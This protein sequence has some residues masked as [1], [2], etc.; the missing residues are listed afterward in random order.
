MLGFAVSTLAEV[1]KPC[2]AFKAFEV[3]DALMK[4]VHAIL[5]IRQPGQNG[6]AAEKF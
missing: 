3:V 2:D 6:R 5:M 4:S 1:V